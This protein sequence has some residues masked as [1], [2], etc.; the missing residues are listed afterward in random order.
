MTPL[1]HA[2]KFRGPCPALVSRDVA[3]SKQQ[4]EHGAGDY[5]QARARRLGGG[6]ASR[7]RVERRKGEGGGGRRRIATKFARFLD[8]IRTR[9]RA[10]AIVEERYKRAV[11][12]PR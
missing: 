6:V 8:D 2:S 7:D 1:D 3:D 4:P 11:A 9:T 5:D 10:D 12:V